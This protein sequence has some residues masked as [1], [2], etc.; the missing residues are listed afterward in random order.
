MSAL[1]YG[2]RLA[3]A[4][5]I[6]IYCWRC[7]RRVDFDPANVIE[8]GRP[9]GR[10][11]RC[12]YCHERGL[13]IASPKWRNSVS[14]QIPYSTGIALEPGFYGGTDGPRPEPIVKRRRKKR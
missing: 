3:A 1:T 5:N 7:D 13:C 6:T 8:S 10:R 2:E 11:F 12:I 4:Y 14:G 9:L